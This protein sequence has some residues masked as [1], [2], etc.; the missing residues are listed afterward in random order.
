MKYPFPK[1]RLGQHFLKDQK[2]IELIVCDFEQKCDAIVEPGPGIG[3]LTE[4]LSKLQ[5]DLY[6]FE[7]DK[8]FHETS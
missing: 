3:A 7:K 6:L 4:S 2:T 8:R 1:K 5:K